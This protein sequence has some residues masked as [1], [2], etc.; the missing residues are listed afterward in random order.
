M[1]QLQLYYLGVDSVNGNDNLTKDPP[2]E[3]TFPEIIV[4]EACELMIRAAI[5]IRDDR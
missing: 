5:E 3:L 2:P 1:Y 4:A